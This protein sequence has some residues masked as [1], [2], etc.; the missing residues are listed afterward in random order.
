MRT[1]LFLVLVLLQACATAPSAPSAPVA[2]E[3]AA[4]TTTASGQ[5]I[6]LPAGDARVS[7]WDYE[8]PPGAKLPLHKH[9]H[10]RLALVL[11][12]T[13]EVTNADTGKTARYGPGDLVVESLDQWHF[14][15]NA[16]PATVKLSVIDL[17]PAGVGSNVE[18]KK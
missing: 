11:E 16:G 4:A 2:R 8:I 10:A 15:V 13:L 6:R 17:T 9:P 18:L 12:G 1:A 7:L 14:G 3:R 5:P